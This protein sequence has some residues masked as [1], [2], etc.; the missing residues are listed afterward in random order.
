MLLYINFNI[1]ITINHTCDVHGLS[2]LFVRLC[3]MLDHVLSV[4]SVSF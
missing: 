4:L 2:S 1:Y 3:C